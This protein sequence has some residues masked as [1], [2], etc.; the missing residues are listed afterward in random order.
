[1]K[2]DFVLHHATHAFIIFFLNASIILVTDTLQKTYYFINKPNTRGI[3]KKLEL[4]NIILFT[5][6]CMFIFLTPSK[7]FSF[8]A[9]HRS[10]RVFRYSKQCWSSC[11]MM[12]FNVSVGFFFTSSRSANSVT[13][14]FVTSDERRS[15]SIQ[16]VLS[17]HDM[18]LVATIFNLL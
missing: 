3:Q 15:S 4:C 18:H 12:P 1:M 5:W 6:F 16:T 2:S 17:V 9:M 7:Y 14:A 10:R 13:L 11:E 8:E